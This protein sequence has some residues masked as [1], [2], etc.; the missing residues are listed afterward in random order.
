M[1]TDTD[2]RDAVVNEL[3]Y[4]RGIASS[5]IRVSVDK[6][7]ATLSGVVETPAQRAAAENAA[8][9]VPGIRGVNC[10]IGVALTEAPVITPN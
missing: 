10:E 5:Q 6:G 3:G 1:Q 4:A 9:A 8:M 7:Y 2:L